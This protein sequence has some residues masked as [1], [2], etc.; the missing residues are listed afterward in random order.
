MGGGRADVAGPDDGDLRA[1]HAVLRFCQVTVSPA[2]FD[3]AGPRAVPDRCS[4]PI[5]TTARWF[6]ARHRL[7][8]RRLCQRQPPDDHHQ[9]QEQPADND[10]VSVLA[11]GFGTGYQTSDRPINKGDN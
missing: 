11:A 10:A 7:A 9:P 6:V 4:S 5:A 8:W 1:F 3:R 2:A